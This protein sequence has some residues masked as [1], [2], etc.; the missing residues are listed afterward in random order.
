[1][2]WDEAEKR[3]LLQLT[4]NAEQQRGIQLIGIVAYSFSSIVCRLPLCSSCGSS[5]QPLPIAIVNSETSPSPPTFQLSSV[6]PLRAGFDVVKT[7][8]MW[9]EISA[10]LAE[11]T[12]RRRSPL[13][14]WRRVNETASDW[15][16][17]AEALE[18]AEEFEGEFEAEDEEADDSANTGPPPPQ[19]P[20]TATSCSISH[21]T[22]SSSSSSTACLPEPAP[23]NGL[24]SHVNDA[25]KW[26]EK[27]A[28]DDEY[29]DED[30]C[31]IVLDDTASARS[32]YSGRIV[33]DDDVD[34]W[35]TASPIMK[36]PLH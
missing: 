3:L 1:M 23:R 22:S 29:E 8:V 18:N 27:N 10:A 7:D 19:T 5:P 33:G 28:A 31:I 36:F 6:R 14:C 15:K 2:P 30:D 35:T 25:E 11:Q 4:R 13:A 16:S 32:D 26:E 24:K 20:H 12:G 34:E 17:D 9:E 21:W